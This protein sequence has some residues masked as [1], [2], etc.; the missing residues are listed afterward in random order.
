MR[1]ARNVVSLRALVAPAADIAVWNLVYVFSLPQSSRAEY[2]A[3]AD[4]ALLIFPSLLFLLYGASIAFRTAFQRQ[5]ITVFEIVQSA[6]C[7]LNITSS[8]RQW[9]AN[10][11]SNVFRAERDLSLCGPQ[12]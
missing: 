4:P 10:L 8:E 3:V 5:K 9:I 7:Y 6:I 11:Y 2:A 12:R 1:H